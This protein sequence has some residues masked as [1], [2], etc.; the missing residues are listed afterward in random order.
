MRRFLVIFLLLFQILLLGANAGELSYSATNFDK[1]IEYISAQTTPQKKISIDFQNYEN[2][3][4][5]ANS[6]LQEIFA[7]RNS[8]NI[9]GFFI[10]FANCDFENDFDKN[11]VKTFD[12]TD[13]HTFYYLKNLIF[14]RA[15]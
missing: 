9:D 14:T 12:F 8:N 4:I 3:L 15:P 2:A 11:T 5:S 10:G 6:R 7:Q 1:H 13:Y